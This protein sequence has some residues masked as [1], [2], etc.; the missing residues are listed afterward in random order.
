MENEGFVEGDF[1]KNSQSKNS[2]T[3]R[4]VIDGSE[5]NGSY[6]KGV[7]TNKQWTQEEERE[8][9]RMWAFELS[10]LDFDTYHEFFLRG[11][12]GQDRITEKSSIQKPSRL[13]SVHMKRSNITRE[14]NSVALLK[15]NHGYFCRKLS[16]MCAKRYKTCFTR[17]SKTFDMIADIGNDF[18][19]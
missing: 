7:S 3:Q 1:V 19:L 12:P 8:R 5:R 18:V 9:R 10:C 2:T 14:L 11:Y 15:K 17:K 6:G 13:E 4:W 16:L